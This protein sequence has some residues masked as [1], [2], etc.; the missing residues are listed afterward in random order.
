MTPQQFRSKSGN[1]VSIKD[2]VSHVNFAESECFYGTT[3]RKHRCAGCGKH[4]K[5][6]DV[7]KLP[8]G[9]SHYGTLLACPGCDES[10][11]VRGHG[12][13]QDTTALGLV[14]AVID[15]TQYPLVFSIFEQ[16]TTARP[17]QYV[18]G[19]NGARIPYRDEPTNTQRCVGCGNHV[20]RT[21][22][23]YFWNQSK[24]LACLRC[25]S[26]TGRNS[27]SAATL[28]AVLAAEL[29]R[30]HPNNGSMNIDDFN[31]TRKQKLIERAMLTSKMLDSAFDDLAS[32][33]TPTNKK[34]ETKEKTMNEN[35]NMMSAKS[36][37]PVKPKEDLKTKVV[38]EASVVG[39]SVE[40]GAKMAVTN[41]AGEVLL[42]IAEK[43][44]E[45]VPAVKLLLA[46]PEGRE[47]AKFMLAMALHATAENTA[48]LPKGD[49]I[50]EVC[51]LQMS[52]SSYELINP[53][54]ALIRG[55]SEQLAGIGETLVATT[56]KNS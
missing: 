17:P 20:T 1:L 48:L 43:L 44:S 5:T 21:N 47:I 9:W 53:R 28:G 38:K 39:Q 6:N 12:I 34:Q 31:K 46:T 22:G 3:K 7:T 56:T 52:V 32:E 51:K 11:V 14:F 26:G 16:K 19:R 40:L 35:L 55:F 15:R 50:A 54:L 36:G 10:K 13:F 2:I 25:W 29:D 27:F 49:L 45:D 8:R 33:Q 4:F 37:G 24:M 23:E 30:S 18:V 42:N 41:Q